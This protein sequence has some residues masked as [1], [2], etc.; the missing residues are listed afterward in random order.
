MFI[1]TFLGIKGLINIDS[2]LE[3]LKASRSTLNTESNLYYKF[4][5]RAAWN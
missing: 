2:C 5:S 1:N 3:E 4:T